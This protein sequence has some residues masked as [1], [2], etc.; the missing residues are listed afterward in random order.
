MEVKGYPGGT[1]TEG[2]TALH[3]FY[4]LWKAFP[5][6]EKR[7]VVRGLPQQIIDRL[8]ALGGTSGH[9]EMTKGYDYDSVCTAIDVELYKLVTFEMLVEAGV[10]VA[11]ST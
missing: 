7:Q 11:A 5:G 9:A 2:G 3:S 8:A 10:F 4:N 6:V 1:V